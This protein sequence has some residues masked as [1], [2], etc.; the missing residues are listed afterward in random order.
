MLNRRDIFT[1][2]I[3]VLMGLSSLSVLAPVSEASSPRASNSVSI[4]GFSFGPSSLTIDTG[5]SVTW[6]NNDGASHTATSTS[7]PVSFDSGGISGGGTYTFSFTTAGTYDYRCDIHTSMTASITVVAPNN[8]PEVSGV[9]ISPDPA[10]TNDVIS[11]SSS[12]SDADGDSVTLS[13]SWLVN[14]QAISETSQTLSG[15]SSFDKGD[16]IQVD[17]TPNDG[18]ED[19]ASVISNSIII[20]NTLPSISSVT[21][22]PSTLN[23]ETIAACTTSGWLDDDGDVEGYEYSWTVNGAVHQATTQSSGPFNADDVISCAATPDDGEGHGPQLSSSDVTVVAVDAPDADADGVPDTTDSCPQTPTSEAVDVHGCSASQRDDDGDGVS[24]ADDICPQT[25]VGASVDNDGCAASQLDSDG[26]GISD[27]SDQCEGFDDSIDV[28]EDGIP[29]D[30]DPLIDTGNDVTFTV[31]SGDGNGT[32]SYICADMDG[33]DSVENCMLSAN[34]SLASDSFASYDHPHFWQWVL[35]SEG[36]V[37]E[38]GDLAELTLNDVNLTFSWVGEGCT[39]SEC[40]ST[41]VHQNTHRG[42][43]YLRPTD[44][45]WFQDPSLVQFEDGFDNNSTW[46]CFDA[47]GDYPSGLVIFHVTE[48][49]TVCEIWEQDNPDLVDRA[50]P[51]GEMDNGCPHYGTD[52]EGDDPVDD[53]VSDDTDTS[54]PERLESDDEPASDGLPGFTSVLMFTAIAGALM[55]LKSR[56]IE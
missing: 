21:I 38:Q 32:T 47:V 25:P 26:D 10:F 29:D 28:D 27:S 3:V 41:T 24:D 48:E 43:Y 56:R 23:N 40:Q 55:H 11:V 2:L 39:T 30:C 12:T 19:G 31:D 54:L 6:T 50:K 35:Y 52:D 15:T 46:R 14:G 44:C 22:S 53:P 13:Y 7:G 36:V 4:S 45:V 8:P 42:A 33:D 9:S 5:D 18:T 16:Q 49:P 34:F 20:S 51:E 37:I 1:F 17:V